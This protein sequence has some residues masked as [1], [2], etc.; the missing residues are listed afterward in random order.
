MTPASVGWLQHPSHMHMHEYTQSPLVFVHSD[1]LVTM[2]QSL[3]WVRV[4]MVDRPAA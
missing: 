3:L 1:C 4:V 2:I